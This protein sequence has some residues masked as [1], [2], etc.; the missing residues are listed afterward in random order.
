MKITKS[1]NLSAGKLSSYR[2]SRY[3]D[4]SALIVQVETFGYPFNYTA[5]SQSIFVLYNPG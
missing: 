5:A 4:F 3:D 1:V 2:P